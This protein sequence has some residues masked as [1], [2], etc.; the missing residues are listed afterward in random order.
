L[1]D[2]APVVPS[3]GRACLPSSI[4]G[5][6]HGAFQPHLDEMQHAPVNNS[7]RYRLY[8]LGMGDAS[9]VVREVGINDFRVASV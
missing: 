3:L 7:A 4:V 2:A 8:Q 6:F 1:R 9:E 5:F